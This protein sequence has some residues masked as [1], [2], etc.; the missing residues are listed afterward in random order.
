MNV[1]ML[2]TNEQFRM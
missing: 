2:F 1:Q